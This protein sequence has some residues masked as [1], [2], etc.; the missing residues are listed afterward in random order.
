M[1][2]VKVATLLVDKMDPGP[3]GFYSAAGPVV[4]ADPTQLILYRQRGATGVQA[5]AALARSLDDAPR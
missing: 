2:P 1:L 5:A 4:A 3:S